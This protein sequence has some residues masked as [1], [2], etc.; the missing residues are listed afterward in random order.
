MSGDPTCRQ[1]TTRQEATMDATA[2]AAA[3]HTISGDDGEQVPLGGMDIT[4]KITGDQT[5]GALAICE[6]AIEPGRLI[7]AHLHDTEDEFSY[8]IEGRIGVL[9]GEE[10]FTAD[11]GSWVRKPRGIA[12]TFWNPGPN[13]A[14]TIEIISP[15]GFE[16]FFREISGIFSADGPPDIERL[17]TTAARYHHHFRPDLEQPLMTK[18]N[19]RVIG[20]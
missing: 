15:A 18:H 3:R 12:H 11:A 9:V 4:F 10:E 5:G 16:N 19:V 13:Y 2:A 8:V 14:R 17:T 7:P 1:A 6:I 20:T